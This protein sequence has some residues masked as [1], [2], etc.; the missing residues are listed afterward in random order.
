MRRGRGKG[1]FLKKSEEE[2][3]NRREGCAGRTL[4]GWHLQVRQQPEE[5]ALFHLPAPQG[6]G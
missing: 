1:P 3:S 5:A 2:E 6:K 4:A